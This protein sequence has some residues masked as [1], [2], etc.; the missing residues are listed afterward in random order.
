MYF[1]TKSYLKSNHYHTTKHPRRR[2]TRKARTYIQYRTSF[3]LRLSFYSFERFIIFLSFQGC[4]II[5]LCKMVCYF[6]K[7]KNSISTSSEL[8]FLPTLILFKFMFYIYK[9][10]FSISILV[11]TF[12]INSIMPNTKHFLDLTECFS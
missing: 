8:C 7:K 10:N 3:F 2:G 1:G 5:M 11:L 9:N 4:I 12:K 6:K